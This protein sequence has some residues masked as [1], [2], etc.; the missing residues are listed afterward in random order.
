MV[1]LWQLPSTWLYQPVVRKSVLGCSGADT[2]FLDFEGARGRRGNSRNLLTWDGTIFDGRWYTILCRT[3]GPP[4]SK[5]KDNIVF[6]AL[7]WKL[8]KYNIVFGALADWYAAYP[9]HIVTAADSNNKHALN[10]ISC[11]LFLIRLSYSW[12][13][14]VLPKMEELISRPFLD[15]NSIL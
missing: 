1:W 2:L 10:I 7:A 14:L 12:S 4:R 9:V 8:Q 5:Q 13:N 11:L 15:E 3:H 6:G